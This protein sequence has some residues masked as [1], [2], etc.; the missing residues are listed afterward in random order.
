MDRTAARARGPGREFLMPTPPPRMARRLKSFE[1]SRRSPVLARAVPN[2]P[3]PQPQHDPQAESPE[4]R[5][6]GAAPAPEDA[7]D[8]EDSGS[9]SSFSGPPPP[10]SVQAGGPGRFAGVL[11]AARAW[12]PL[13][14]NPPSA[15][16]QA[17]TG[18]DWFGQW[19]FPSQ[20]FFFS[21]VLA[22]GMWWL[23]GGEPSTAAVDPPLAARPA[24]KPRPR[25]RPETFD[26]LN[27]LRE[28]QVVTGQLEAEFVEAQEFYREY[29]LDEF[30]D[31]DPWALGSDEVVALTHFC[32]E[33]FFTVE[34]EILITILER[35]VVD[36]PSATE[37]A[38]QGAI[39]RLES[40]A[41]DS[42]ARLA[43]LREAADLYRRG[44]SAEVRIPE[45]MTPEEDQA[46]RARLVDKLAAVRRERERLDARIHELGAMLR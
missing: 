10:A 40:V 22:A 26:W 17:P 14:G 44:R 39:A 32:D 37:A 6:I 24:A 4:T 33:G 25:V 9:Q 16:G 12:A 11:P 27:R 45:A 3:P 42:E 43:G 34:R 28:A 30:L 2:R 21:L 46:Q 7:G 23:R 38:P 19:A 36:R 20:L 13:S 5:R 1:R 31:F 15:G 35:K 8:A 41:R 18:W 29:A